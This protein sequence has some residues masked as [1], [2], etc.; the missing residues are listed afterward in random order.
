MAQV[1]FKC[2]KVLVVESNQRSYLHLILRKNG[3]TLDLS[4]EIP[5]FHR[6]NNDNRIISAFVETMDSFLRSWS[7]ERGSW[8]DLLPWQSS[9]VQRFLRK[10][11]KMPKVFSVHLVMRSQDSGKLLEFLLTDWLL[12]L[13]LS[14]SYYRKLLSYIKSA[15]KS[16]DLCVFCISCHELFDAVIQRHKVQVRVPVITDNEMEEKAAG[17]QHHRFM[18]DGTK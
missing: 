18:K 11:W 10:F 12:N 4:N 13:F 9:S 6:W 3:F 2:L 5:V 7:S 15:Q 8:C 16:I 17:S 14:S 1:V